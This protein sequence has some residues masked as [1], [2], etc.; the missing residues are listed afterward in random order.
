MGRD[1]VKEACDPFPCESARPAA[2]HCR[3]AGGE[4]LELGRGD[5]VRQ[6]RLCPREGDRDAGDA[7]R[8]I[9]PGVDAG[10]WGRLGEVHT[11]DAD[12]SSPEKAGRKVAEGVMACSVPDAERGLTHCVGEELTPNGVEV[13]APRHG[14]EAEPVEKAGLSDACV[15]HHDDFKGARHRAALG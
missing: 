15:P 13:P 2:E 5:A 12:V 14:A 11:H 4:P 7:R 8:L 10:G 6:I 1:V 3:V 9:D